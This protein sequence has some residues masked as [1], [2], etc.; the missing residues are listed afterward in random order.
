[1][2]QLATF[3]PDEPRIGRW[4]TR[5]PLGEGGGI[6]LYQYAY[7][8][9]ISTT[10]PAGLWGAGVTAG[11]SAEA[12]IPGVVG[13]GGTGSVG[14]GGFYD[15]DTGTGSDGVFASGGA[16]AAGPCGSASFPNVPGRKGAA[17][18]FAGVGGGIFLTNAPNVGALGGPFD[19]YTVNV[20]V[21]P[22]Q[23]SVQFGYSDGIGIL[24]VTA[25]PGAG[26]SASEYPTTTVTAPGP[27]TG[28]Q[29]LLN[30]WNNQL[31]EGATSPDPFSQ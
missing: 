3:R 30:D 2:L 7:A 29:N 16:F 15:P 28:T 22:L 10:D 25:G 1:M 20:G 4:Q 8:N 19:T 12:G 21:G 5:D 11:G 14:Y 23:F 18:G 13:A 31:M 27:L 24:S 17:G 26:L 9:P 6:N